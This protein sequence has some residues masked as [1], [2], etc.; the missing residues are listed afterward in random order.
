MK[1]GDACRREAIENV[2]RV[3]RD[4]VEMLECSG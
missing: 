2:L 3:S 1:L 4:P